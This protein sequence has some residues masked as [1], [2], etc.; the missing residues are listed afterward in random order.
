MLDAFSHATPRCLFFAQTFPA[1][2]N[3]WQQQLLAGC[4]SWQ[5]RPCLRITAQLARV[6]EKLP[7]RHLAGAR[8]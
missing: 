1:G 7:P 8:A 5:Q 6:A 3:S 4:N 2:C